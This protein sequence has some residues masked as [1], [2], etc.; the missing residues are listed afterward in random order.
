MFAVKELFKIGLGRLKAGHGTCFTWD[1]AHDD[2]RK[3]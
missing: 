2:L 3:G 1:V